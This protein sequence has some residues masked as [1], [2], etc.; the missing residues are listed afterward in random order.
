MT[1]VSW[2]DTSDRKFETG[3]SN[4]V[5]YLPTGGIAWNGL[6]S[7]EEEQGDEIQSFYIDGRKYL[8]LPNPGDFAGTLMVYTYPKEFGPYIGDVEIKPGLFV[9]NQPLQ[10]FDISYQTIVGDSVVGID[11][12][13][14]IHLLYNLTAIED[15]TQYNSMSNQITPNN[16]SWKIQGVPEWVSGYRPTA[17]AVVDTSRSNPYFI[18]ELTD[19]LYGT[20]STNPR[21]PPL[22]ELVTLADNWS[23]I[24]IT[25]HGDGTWSATGPEE[26][27]TINA[28]GTF[29]I[30]NVEGTIL[31][32]DSYSITTTTE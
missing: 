11:R 19:I 7:F 16:L 24:T 25:D 32:A 8:D 14:K 28:D 27:F 10:S 23:L 13:R 9:D 2:S 1:R 22:Q 4:G 30:R 17:H 5:L 31:D 6:Q 21:L 26:Y 12:G 15:A 18:E 29:E 20:A 3:I